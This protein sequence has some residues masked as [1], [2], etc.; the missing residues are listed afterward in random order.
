MQKSFIHYLLKPVPFDQL[1]G[2]RNSKQQR[3]HPATG[4]LVRNVAIA[5]FCNDDKYGAEYLTSIL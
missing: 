5:E 1:L 3:R 4:E 2:H